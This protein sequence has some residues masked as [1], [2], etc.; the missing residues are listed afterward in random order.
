M[1]LQL[2]ENPKGSSKEKVFETLNQVIEQLT[3]LSEGYLRD[4]EDDPEASAK[5]TI[6]GIICYIQE[7][8]IYLEDLYQ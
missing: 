5:G 8:L 7:D 3:D 2:N 6:D 1:N 4:F